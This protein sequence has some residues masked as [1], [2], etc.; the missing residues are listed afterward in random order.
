MKTHTNE[1]KNNIK[2]FGRELDTAILYNLEGQPIILGG[3]V[4][5][6][7]SL[8]YEG[9]ILKSVM[10]QLDIDCNI[11]IP[12]NTPLSI[13]TGVKVRNDEDVETYREN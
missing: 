3:D 4:I 13:V 10:K 6:S 11:D 5:N 1:F 12:V 2:L 8:H 7:V 9:S